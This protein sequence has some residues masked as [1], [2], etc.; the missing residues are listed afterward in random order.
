MATQEQCAVLA[1]QLRV[2]VAV[3]RE[4]GRALPP[5]SPPAMV[6]LLSAL[7]HCG[8][9]RMS[10][11]AERLDIDMSVVS[12]HVAYAADRGWIDRDPDPLDKRSRLL[13]LT[14]DGETVLRA[15]SARA[16][17]VLADHLSEWP[18]EDVGQL[19]ALLAR[20]RLSFGDCRPRAHAPRRH[21]NARYEG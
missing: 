1:D 2:V 18:D 7:D 20:L 15:A 9:V 10:K 16:T 3:G 13:R 17:D 4:I 14:A 6:A 5:E 21:T 12:R 11:L 8:Q 19:A